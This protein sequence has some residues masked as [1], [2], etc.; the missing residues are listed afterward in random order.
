MRDAETSR[1]NELSMSTPLS[2]AVQ[3]ALVEL[4]RAW[5]ISPTAVTSHSSGEVPAAY[6]AGAITMRT[7]MDIC[8]AR[9]KHAGQKIP[10]LGKGGMI[11]VGLGPDD[12]QSYL[13][14]LTKGR[15]VIACYNSPTSITA[16]GDVLGVEELEDLLKAD[17]IFARRLRIDCAY[18]SHH[19]KA[20]SAPYYD[21]LA[22]VMTPE[23]SMNG[24]VIFSSPTTG[25]RETSGLHISGAQHWVD[26]LTRP[27]SF[28]QAFRNMCFDTEENETSCVD[29]V[30][31]VGPHA[32]LSGPIHEIVSQP[33]FHGVTIDYLPTLV[34]KSSAITT[35]QDL[36]SSLVK[37]GYT[38]NMDAVNFP[39]GRP[40]TQALSTTFL[41]TPGT[42]R[43][44]T[45]VNRDSTRR[46]VIALT[47]F[48]TYLVRF[49]LVQTLQ[50]R[51]GVTSFVWQMC[52]GY[53][54]TSSNLTSS[55]LVP[56]SSAWLL[57]PLLNSRR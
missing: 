57:R 55:T 31:E 6:A 50:H 10:G 34:R 39:Y 42:I 14:R 19:M 25:K 32:A 40:N 17:N 53:S 33:E 3:I 8:Y 29:M 30:I 44:N 41:T 1:V 16:S 56:G 4:L 26:S 2:V 51:L 21:W 35:I 27:V 5:G 37:A 11:A 20:I 18:H 13:D 49:N 12:A 43:P 36:A 48:T 9:A 54:T 45:G 28:T 52:R 23:D 47:K 38:I 15:V 22:R 46:C 24:A 7:A